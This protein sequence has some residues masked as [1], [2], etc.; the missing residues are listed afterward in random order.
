MPQRLI[1]SQFLDLEEPAEAITIP[2]AWAPDQIVSAI[3]SRI[4]T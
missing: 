4:G 1:E 3:R 2:A